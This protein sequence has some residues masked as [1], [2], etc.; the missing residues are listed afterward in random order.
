MEDIISSVIG[1]L[2]T[3]MITPGP[4]AIIA[5]LV[6]AIVLIWIDR[7]RLIKTIE[8]KDDRIDRIIDQYYAGHLS[9]TDAL[10]HIESAMLEM[11]KRL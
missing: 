10:G 5:L 9:L 6:L 7:N 4:G 11:A 2:I 1:A 3:F 8:K